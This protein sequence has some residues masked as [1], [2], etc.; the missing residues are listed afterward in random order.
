MCLH[1]S[2][3]KLDDIQRFAFNHS[4]T[5]ELVFY[6][7]IATTVVCGVLLTTLAI[8]S[9]KQEKPDLTFLGFVRN[10]RVKPPRY[11]KIASDVRL[12]T[13]FYALIGVV[14]AARGDISMTASF[15]AM[16]LMIQALRAW[17]RSR[18]SEA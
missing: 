7:A 5:L 8:W 16:I 11:K 6:I 13:Y 17:A 1:V 10:I 14:E 12:L 2:T 9:K 18:I 15:I 3:G 4:M